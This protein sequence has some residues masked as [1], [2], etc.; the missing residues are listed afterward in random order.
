MK[1]ST[2]KRKLAEQEVAL[3]EGRH[4]RWLGTRALPGAGIKVRVTCVKTALREI[5]LLS[6]CEQAAFLELW[7]DDSV[8]TVYDQVAIPQD[9]SLKAA[10]QINVEHPT[11]KRGGE[12]VVITTDLVAIRKRDGR[13]QK[14]AYSVKERRSFKATGE[15]DR[16]RIERRVWENEGAEF[17]VFIADGMRAPRSKNLAWL[18]AAEND[19]TGRPLS[20]EEMSAQKSLLFHMRRRIGMLVVDACRAVDAEAELE[21]G[22]GARAFRQLAATKQIAFDLSS[23]DP[24]RIPVSEIRL[25][26]RRSATKQNV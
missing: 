13:L 5:H 17:K 18:L 16:Q 10:A 2:L 7:W 26:I 11:Y 23:E 8:L 3:R 20:S 6:S 24:I 25:E 14:M 21:P 15:N 9:V 22:C 1:P 19:M 4:L 12:L